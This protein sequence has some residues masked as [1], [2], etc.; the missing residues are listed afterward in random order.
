M[1]YFFLWPLC[2]IRD[3]VVYAP[4][5]INTLSLYVM[6]PVHQHDELSALQEEN[7]RLRGRIAHLEATSES[8]RQRVSLLVSSEGVTKRDFFTAVESVGAQNANSVSQLHEWIEKYH[9]ALEQLREAKESVHYWKSRSAEVQSSRSPTGRGTLKAPRSPRLGS[10]DSTANTTRD[11]AEERRKRAALTRRVAQLEEAH[12]QELS[13][14][15]ESILALSSQLTDAQTVLAAV[16]RER[17]DSMTQLLEVRAQA[18]PHEATINRLEGR[19]AALESERK[20]FIKTAEELQNRLLARA[21][22]ERRGED[23]RRAALE[24]EVSALTSKLAMTQTNSDAWEQ[25]AAALS[26]E[27]EL[28]QDSLGATQRQNEE[29][30]KMISDRTQAESRTTKESVS[31]ILARLGEVVTSAEK[32]ANTSAQGGVAQLAK[33]VGIAE[34]LTKSVDQYAAMLSVKEKQLNALLAEIES[35]ERVGWP[36][37]TGEARQCLLDVSMEGHHQPPPPREVVVRT[38]DGDWKEIRDTRR[39]RLYYVTTQV[40]QTPFGRPQRGGSLV[41]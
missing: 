38:A 13:A 29:L 19:V 25:Q 24:L 37:R 16:E 12:A 33:R 8:F 9:D 1:C 14:K 23:E 15:D 11:S 3:I 22:D 31:L 10:V 21:A 6:E 4:R 34:T 5:G 2:M 41:R 35:C 17:N 39:N 28:L 27:T 32:A 30:R 20:M 36:L 40:E 7:S 26:K 18:V